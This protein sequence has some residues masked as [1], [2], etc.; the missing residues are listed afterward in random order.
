MNKVLEFRILGE[1][2]QKSSDSSLVQEQQSAIVRELM[3][4]EHHFHIYNERLTGKDIHAM[5]FFSVLLESGSVTIVNSGEEILIDSVLRVE[6]GTN[7]TYE[8]SVRDFIRFTESTPGKVGKENIDSYL[9]PTLNFVGMHIGMITE[10]EDVFTEAVLT[11]EDSEVFRAEEIKTVWEDGFY[12]CSVDNTDGECM[13]FT[14]DDF[15]SPMNISL[16]HFLCHTHCGYFGSGC[17]A[18][19][20]LIRVELAS[21][22]G[23]YTHTR[24]LSFSLLNTLILSAIDR[25]YP[26]YSN[27]TPDKRIKKFYDDVV[28]PL[29]SEEYLTGEFEE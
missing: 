14:P 17:S 13:S 11:E 29:L 15:L 16:L 3:K 19:E 23:M 10:A 21:H 26:L 27:Y 5:D 9:V 4:P 12:S 8:M 2:A 6:K 22:E 25:K 18:D 7:D 1:P 20:E 24:I 28:F